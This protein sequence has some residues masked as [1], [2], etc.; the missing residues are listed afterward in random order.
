MRDTFFALLVLHKT[1][2][3][4][5]PFV[6]SYSYFLTF[7][8]RL[9]CISSK[10]EQFSTF[11]LLKTKPL[12]PVEMS[13]TTYQATQLHITKE[14][15]GYLYRCENIKSRVIAGILVLIEYLINCYIFN[16]QCNSTLISG[17]DLNNGRITYRQII[18]KAKVKQ[19]HYRPGQALR[20]PGG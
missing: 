3:V 20:V 4:F 9:V 18:I 1:K 7:R 17:S 19:S 14:S 12:L 16:R 13:V 2:R 5:I 11:N 15:L 10:A 8:R 6:M